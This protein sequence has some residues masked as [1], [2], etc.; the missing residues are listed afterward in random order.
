MADLANLR[1][2]VDSRDVKSAGADLDKLGRSADEA[3]RGA[4]RVSSAF[5]NMRSTLAALG[6]GAI[7]IDMVRTNMEFQRLQA[8]LTVATGSAVNATN[9]FSEIRKFAATTPYELNQSVEA[10]LRLKNLGLDPSIEAMRSYGNTASA[11]GKD[12]MQMVEAV[13]D[14]STGEFERLKEFGIKASKSAN[15]VAFTFQGVTTKVGNNA[16]EIQKYL[17]DIGNTKFA[18]GMEMQ[19]QTLGGQF[20]NLKDNLDAFYVAIGNAGANSA[21][22]QM[23]AQLSNVLVAATANIDSIIVALETAAIAIAAYYT[24]VGVAS[25]YQAAMAASAFT[26]SGALGILTAAVSSLN[27]AMLANPAVWF[28]AAIASVGYVFLSMRSNTEAANAALKRNAELAKDAGVELTAAS[29]AALSAA[30]ENSNLGDQTADAANTTFT[31]T[32]E[33][34]K[35]TV[36]LQQQAVAARNAT[37][38]ILRKKLAES[39]AIE[40]ASQETIVRGKGLDPYS[41]YKRLGQ[42]DI[43]GAFS[44]FGK[45]LN[46]GVQ[47]LL[48]GGRTV[49]EAV[50]NYK[51]AALISLGLQEKINKALSDPVGTGDLPTQTAG[52]IANVGKKAKEAADP[53][54]EFTQ[55]IERL[56][57]EIANID[58]TPLDARMREIDAMVAKAN[59]KKLEGS[60]AL[61]RDLGKSL[62]ELSENSAANKAE[63][64]FKSLIEQVKQ[65]TAVIGLSREATE[66]ANL[67]AEKTAFIA[68]RKVAV[69]LERATQMWNEYH[70]ARVKGLNKQ[71][72]LD[73]DLE[74]VKELRGILDGI[75]GVI[76]GSVGKALSM[77]LG[78]KMELPDE[79]FDEFG[80]V[81]AK[82]LG[83]FGKTLAAM[84][85]GFTLGKM[86][87]SGIGGAIGGALGEKVLGSAI[88]KVAGAIGGKIGGALGQFAGPLGSIAG[89]LLGGLIGGLFTKTKT[90]TATLTQVAGGAM[91]KTLG[92]NNAQLKGVADKMANGLLTALG[93]VAEQLG[94]TL[95]GAVNI[96]VGMRKKDY[97][98]DPTGKGRTKGAGVM[99]FGEDAA[100]AAAYATQLAIQQGII[101]G[102]SAG[103]QTLIKAGGDLNAQVQKA[104][105]FDQVFKDLKKETDPLGASL[106]E[107]A[108]EMTKLKAIFGEAGASAEDYAK[109]EELFAIKQAKAIFEANKPRR[110]LE[111]QLMEA[112]GNAAGALA[113]RRQL[114][115]ESMDA[116]LRALQQQVWAAEDAAKAAQELAD[117]NAKAAEEAKAAAEAA[118][119]L[120]A[121]RRS[122]EIDL[123]EALGNSAEALA[124]RRKIELEAMDASLRGLQQ[125]IWAALDAKAAAEAAAEAAQVLAEEQAK[126]AEAAAKLATEKR[127]L[128]IQLLEAQGFAIEALTARRAMEL[129]ATD[130]SLRSLKEAIWAAQAK[131]EADAAAA[132]AAEEAAAAEAKA[133]QDAADAMQKYMETLTDVSKTVQEEINRLRGINASSTSVLLKAQ[134]ATLTAQARTGNLDALGKLPELSKAIEEATIGTAGSALEVARIR[135]WLSSSLAETLGAQAAS[136]AEVNTAGA[137]LVFDGN[138]T[139]TATTAQTADAISNMRGDLYSAL[140]QIAKN[141]GK[142]YELMDRWDGDGLPDIREDAS[143]YY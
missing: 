129:E 125:Q 73:E 6:L 14:A 140:Y 116:G 89:G 38:E 40:A 66:L 69:G 78:I 62:K 59:S 37:I 92:G 31:F 107:L 58:G 4:K 43:T 103:A 85:Q 79:T 9:A 94:G 104:L 3:E 139:T 93:N 1:I 123:M 41:G 23:L 18:G 95:G 112:Q 91:Q 111:I 27:L 55:Y 72:A 56:R 29:K 142:S 108:A 32:D 68:E 46:A 64:S 117:A 35:S 30:N 114:E 12:L 100:A 113:A 16:S 53:T 137:G 51:Q 13:A 120:A 110:E 54:E 49:R 75:T 126:A 101:T 99:N 57:E 25:A 60:A 70:D 88:G 76:G 109:L 47:N 42:G 77:T 33:L 19:M 82:A 63:N 45:N 44:E 67:E 143:D 52:A 28:A 10:F 71:T 11:M 132:K 96:S 20:S 86:T 121:D 135:A 26:T 122:M 90:G 141:T 124:A 8:A 84:T 22:S 115:L 131:A 97:V 50:T 15:Q 74:R 80:N 21:L 83:G 134:F 39:K 106:D 61:I 48:S 119:A 24:A 17:L 127:E 130:A 136:N 118:N 34:K 5:A 98:V 102:I 2:S 105:K 138:Q 65:Q 133:A 128:E 87:G 81:L 36:A 7:A